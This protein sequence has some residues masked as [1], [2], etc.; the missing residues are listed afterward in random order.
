[1]NKALSHTI[2]FCF[3]LLFWAG[4]GAPKTTAIP[5]SEAHKKFLKICKE[6]YA[7]ENIRLT[8]LENTVWIYLPIDH[9]FVNAKATRGGKV[10]SKEGKEGFAVNYC[11]VTFKDEVFS[12]EYDISKKRSYA[13]DLGYGS[14]NNETFTKKYQNI[15]AAIMQSYFEIKDES[16]GLEL[17]EE[18]ATF[19][20]AHVIRNYVKDPTAPDFFVIVIANV[21]NGI[22]LKYTLYLEDYKRQA[23]GNFPQEEATMR[24]LNES[25][26]N[27]NAIDDVEGKFLNVQE[28][29]WPDFLAKQMVNRINFKF[30]KSEFA[31]SEDIASEVMKI[32]ATTLRYYDF[33]DLAS[34]DLI[35]LN[36]Q[37]T[38][39]AD[40]AELEEITENVDVPSEGKY[41]VIKF[42]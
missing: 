21:N 42:F 10:T 6:D 24:I 13:K 1:M 31:P 12:V 32:A 36:T 8:P 28:I 16:L 2:L 37:T 9:D 22:I 38:T 33:T 5:L 27:I 20:D 26:G 30:G 41:H 15:Y 19:K 14:Q 11:D 4:C 34:I 35:D 3:C 40:K 29:L 23:M 18:D 17:N 25:Y 39:S 7:L